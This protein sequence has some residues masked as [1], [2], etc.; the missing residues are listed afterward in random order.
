MPVPPMQLRDEVEASL[1]PDVARGELEVPIWHDNRMVHSVA[2]P[3][4]EFPGVHL[5][6]A[7]DRIREVVQS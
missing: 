6:D 7:S 3:L 1:I 2:Y 4:K 5:S